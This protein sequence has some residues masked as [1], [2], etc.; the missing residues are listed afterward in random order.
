MSDVLGRLVKFTSDYDSGLLGDP[1]MRA[2]DVGLV[3]SYWNQHNGFRKTSAI[4]ILTAKGF[5]AG[6]WV[7]GHDG[8]ILE[9]VDG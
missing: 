5:V 9:F 4:T 1:H 6:L 7:P 8:A 2:S 3:V